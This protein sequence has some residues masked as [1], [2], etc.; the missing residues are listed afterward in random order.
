MAVRHSRIKVEVLA[1]TAEK[2]IANGYEDAASDMVWDLQI[3]IVCE[4]FEPGVF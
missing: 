2:L 4:T 3:I 1:E